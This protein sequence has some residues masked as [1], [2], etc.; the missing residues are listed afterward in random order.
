MMNAKIVIYVTENFSYF[1]ARFLNEIILNGWTQFLSM[2]YT[3]LFNE[4]FSNTS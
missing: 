3:I 2:F 1:S 4:Y